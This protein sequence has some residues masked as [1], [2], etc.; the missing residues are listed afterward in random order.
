MQ[1]S[2]K[3]QVCGEPA[4]GVASSGIGAISFAYCQECLN[5][6]A[7]PFG[8][9]VA[10]LSMIGGDENA[11]ENLHAMIEATLQRVGKTKEELDAAVQKAIQEEAEF[12]KQVDQE[13]SEMRQIEIKGMIYVPQDVSKGEFADQFNKWLE[14]KGW[15][16]SGGWW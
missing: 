11:G 4:K 5:V 8:A 7:E 2:L 13:L 3:C 15:L 6:G 9:V 16:F 14:S 1:E 10:L 12:D